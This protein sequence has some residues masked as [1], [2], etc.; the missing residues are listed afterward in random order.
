MFKLH[1]LHIEFKFAHFYNYLCHSFC[2][3][4]RRFPTPLCQNQGVR[5]FFAGRYRLQ[6]LP[7][8]ILDKYGNT[9]LYSTKMAVD[10]IWVP[11]FDPKIIY[12]C[13]FVDFRAK[14]GKE[15]YIWSKLG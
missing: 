1:Y 15:F 3:N 14:I 2:Q 13:A 8:K 10:V 4:V 12:F 11:K 9:E 6:N 7:A 5:K